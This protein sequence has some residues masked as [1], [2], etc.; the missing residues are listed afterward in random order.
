MDGFSTHG[1]LFDGR[2]EVELRRYCDEAE[3]HIA[4]KAH[5]E[6]RKE[7]HEHFKHPTGYYE[8]HVIVR[9]EPGGHVV[10]DQGVVYGPWLEGTGSR[11]FP[12][13]RFKGYANF[14]RVTARINAQAKDIA[15]RVLLPYLRR[16]G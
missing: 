12:R 15:E 1:P 14:R 11:N 10:T 16:I 3:K 2:A 13:T 7:F 9:D 5:G 6:L 8:S 4:E